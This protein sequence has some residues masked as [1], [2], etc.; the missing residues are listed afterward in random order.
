MTQKGYLNDL[1]VSLTTNIIIVINN[2][3]NNKHIYLNIKLYEDM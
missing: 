2:T 3:S 1:K